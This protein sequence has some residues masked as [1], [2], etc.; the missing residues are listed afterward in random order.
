MNAT[1]VD[2]FSSSTAVYVH[3]ETEASATWQTQLKVVTIADRSNTSNI[4][5]LL[6]S[7]EYPL[8][9][10]GSE[11]HH[12]DVNNNNN[13]GHEKMHGKVLTSDT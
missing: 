8:M 13:R 11:G 1:I 3:N 7:P 2:L 4:S 6:Q 12:G 9:I 5:A 10:G